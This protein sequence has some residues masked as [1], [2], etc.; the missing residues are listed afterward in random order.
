MLKI[1]EPSQLIDTQFTEPTYSDI[2]PAGAPVLKNSILGAGDITKMSQNAK[3][4]FHLSRRWIGLK[5]RRTL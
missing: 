1:K 2:T 5:I 4:T 3:M